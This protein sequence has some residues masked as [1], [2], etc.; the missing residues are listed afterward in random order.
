MQIATWNVN[1]LR[2]RLPHVLD[3]LKANPVDVLGLQELKLPDADF[4]HAAFAELGYRAV[5][6]GQKTYNG[7][8]LLARSELHDPCS[9]LPGFGDEQ[10]RVIEATVSGVRVV[11]VYVPN[12]QAV[13]SDKYDYKLRWLSALRAHLA[14]L[15]QRHDQVAVVGDYN[16]AP[17]DLDVHDPAAW[18]EQV[19]CS[20]PERDAFRA[21]LRLGFVDCYRLAAPEDPGFTWWDYRAAAFR[22]NL[23]LRIDH[24]LA[25]APL[26][27]DLKG[28]RV[29]AA[30]RRL[31]RPSDHAPVIATFVV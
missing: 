7:V 15:L 23:G 31:E 3:W 28:C 26:A 22:R 12:G 16:V 29:D 8:A 5:A 18:H 27:A 11:S 9:D 13:G 20:T 30:P 2:V 17:A 14:G 4:P 6:N 10:K 21:L 19:L 24:V 1:S 25:S